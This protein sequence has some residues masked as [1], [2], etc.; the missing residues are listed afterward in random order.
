MAIFWPGAFIFG[1]PG[2]MGPYWQRILHVGKG[3]IGNTLFFILVP[4]GIFMFLVGRWQVTFGIRRMITVGVI[5]CGLSGIILAYV[6]KVII[7]YLWAFL[8]GLS[9]CF[10]YLPALTTVQHWYP[11]NRGLVTGIVN[12]AF[13]FSAGIMSPIFAHMLESM[14]YISVNII[15]AI[16]A[17]VVGVIAARYTEIP[18]GAV[19]QERESRSHAR[20]SGYGVSSSFT[21]G[22]SI[23]TRSFW[24]LWITWALQGA[25]GS[26]M[27]PVSTMFG[28]SRGFTLQS[29]VAILTAF[30]IMSALS[31]ITMGYLSD[32]VGRNTIMSITF[33]AAGG[34]YFILP[35]VSSLVIAA[36]L[37]A[38]I[39]FSFGTLFALSAPLVADCFGLQHFGV[40]FGLVFTA[41]GFV[42]G[43][44]GPSLSG[45]ILDV[46]RGNFVIVF[47][48]LGIFCV[49]SGF[50]V[51]SV[52]PP[53]D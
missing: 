8:L 22:E 53:T 50:L 48:Y 19:L 28:L 16:I 18:A 40:I 52:L 47:T 14:G 17:L 11:E 20:S 41:Y 51:R 35:Y 7:L 39:G 30:N 27:V 9:S 31:R 45:Y 24:F 13:A 29:A 15:F 2:V 6:S 36:S 44:I 5:L 42:S 25:A 43:A 38:I 23:R 49:L 3:P 1:Y 32:I 33:F 34:A 21:A 37:A 26:A 12:M 10:I 4:V 46:S